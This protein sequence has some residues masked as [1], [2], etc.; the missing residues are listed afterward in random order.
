MK[1]VNMLIKCFI[2]LINI[3]AKTTKLKHRD[4]LLKRRKSSLKA[5]QSSLKRDDIFTKT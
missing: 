2:T 1:S 4:V 3:E 5:S